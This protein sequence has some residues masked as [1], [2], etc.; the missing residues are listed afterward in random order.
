MKRSGKVVRRGVSVG[1]AA[2][3][4]G[5]QLWGAPAAAADPTFA[6][7]LGA[8]GTGRASPTS[9]SA[10]ATA[11]SMLAMRT[12]YDLGVGGSLGP[13]KLRRLTAAAVDSTS[14][15]V[16]LG[17]IFARDWSTPGALVSEYPGW[18]RPSDDLDNDLIDTGL[19][20]GLGTALL[21]GHLGVGLGGSYRIRK[22]SF[23]G[24]SDNV[25]VTA[26]LSGNIADQVYLSVTGE[27]LVPQDF[28]SAP[29]RIGTGLRWQAIEAVGI[30]ADGEADLS[31]ASPAYT[32]GF[33]VE[34]VAGGKVPVRAGYRNDGLRE[35]QQVTGGIGVG[36]GEY[37]LE[38]GL[39]VA[40]EEDVQLWHA[41]TVR[42]T[43]S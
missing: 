14:G 26:S 1:A 30:E 19:H 6:A 38:Y 18:R 34:G 43:F 8:A 33:G 27:N 22:T 25:N 24:R 4:G 39:Q 21:N 40:L 11:P 42:V 7:E 12:R 15:P 23:T 36:N 37:F 9:L 13:D 3:F 16:A 28:V 2:L 32:V 31:G 20:L 5:V 41:L 10:I 17:V 29:L 35:Q